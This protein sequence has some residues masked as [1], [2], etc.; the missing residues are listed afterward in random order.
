VQRSLRI[1][2]IATVKG[3]RAALHDTIDS[4]LPQVD[5]IVISNGDV[6]G[7]AVKFSGYRPD[8]FF[9]SCDDDLIYPP[10]YCDK[11]IACY[12][13][14][15][16]IVTCHG[17]IFS[18]PIT[19]Y[20]RN[21]TKFHCLADVE[22]DVTVHCGGTGVMMIAG[23]L[24]ITPENFKEKNMADVW[25]AKL[26]YEQNVPI[27]CMAHKKGWIK[28]TDKFDL[29]ETIYETHKSDCKVQTDV[30]AGLFTNLVNKNAA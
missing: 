25:L 20:Y 12:E 30:V 7:D 24:F 18:P 28:H 8:V 29:K 11:M 15:G 14:T 27:V 4:L 19:D 13:R 1:A 21:G 10:D 9:F 17:R 2:G 16:A 3:R 22:H 26:A 5:S 23:Q 6:I